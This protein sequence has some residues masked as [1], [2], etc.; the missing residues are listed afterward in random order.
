[1]TPIRIADPYAVPGRYCKA[2]LHCHTTNSDGKFTPREL[3][4]R[5]REAGYT[6]VVLTDHERVTICDDLNDSTFLA[7]PGV[8]TAV[9]RPF[10]P[11][12]PHLGRLGMTGPLDVRGAQACVDATVA[13]GG[14]VSLHHPGWTGNLYTGRWSVTEMVRLQR[15]HLIEVSNHHSAVRADVQRWVQVLLR[16][17]PGATVGAVAVDDLHREADFDTGWVMV[18]VDAITPQAFLRALRSLALVASTGPAA[19]FGVHNGAITCATDAARIRFF[20]SRGRVRRDA[21]APE[22]DYVPRGD[23]GFVRIECASGSGQV[24]WSQAFW[25]S[26]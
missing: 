3:L 1:V 19:E 21:D 2:Q 25:I 6:F 20:D 8:E 17:G 14:V 23:E 5:Y 16:R 24:A 9:G 13:A 4:E 15:Y 22:A 12:G 10:R 7:L 11:L 26:P 18:K